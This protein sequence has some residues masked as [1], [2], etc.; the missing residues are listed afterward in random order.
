MPV[1]FRA[2]FERLLE[3][4]P[5]ELF[6]CSLK[7]NGVLGNY[8][9]VVSSSQLAVDVGYIGPSY[10]FAGPASSVAVP[11]QLGFEKGDLIILEGTLGTEANHGK[12]LVLIDPATITVLGTPLV[13]DSPVTYKFRAMKRRA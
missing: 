3:M 9:V 7:G 13:N 8:L 2:F 6:E 12:E 4:S 10:T 1:M 5:R 11:K